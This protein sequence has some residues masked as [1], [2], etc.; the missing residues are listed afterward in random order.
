MKG[1]TGLG[2]FL[3]YKV[4]LEVQESEYIEDDDDDFIWSYWYIVLFVKFLIIY[5]KWWTLNS[6]NAL[7]NFR[8]FEYIVNKYVKSWMKLLNILQTTMYIYIDIKDIWK[9]LLERSWWLVF[10]DRA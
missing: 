10:I 7:Q 8:I 5:N 3:R 4:D 1:F 9:S 2:G 6:K